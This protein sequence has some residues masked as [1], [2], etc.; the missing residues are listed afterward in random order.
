MKS[1]GFP[2]LL[3]PINIF[4]SSVTM[5][6]PITRNMNQKYTLARLY[7]NWLPVSMFSIAVYGSPMSPIDMAR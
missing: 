1:F 2:P 5:K 6:Y 7:I 3:A 4:F